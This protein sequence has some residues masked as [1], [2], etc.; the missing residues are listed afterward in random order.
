VTLA[1]VA[2]LLAADP[3]PGT[4]VMEGG[5]GTA[6][7]S[8]GH[9]TIE[10]VGA[11]AHSCSL[12]GTWSGDKG[13]VSDEGLPCEVRFTMNGEAMEISAVSEEACRAWCGARARFTGTYVLPP[14]SC[15][16]N[17]V[18]QTRATFKKQY[19]Q[20]HWAEAVATLAPLL[21][22]CS[23]VLDRFDA[24]WV[25][26]DLAIAQHH[27]GDD[28]ACL[29]TLMPLGAFRDDSGDDLAG[30]EPAFEELIKKLALATRTNAKLCGYASKK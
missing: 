27:A 12:A 24:G 19:A 8:R 3:K 26:N 9:F 4:W 6:V 29:M 25:R 30:A 17:A 16:A 10:T 23:N 7:L 14:K 2:L 15:A 1:L 13:M 22:A 21:S 11:N 28:A 5:F 20:K 18:K